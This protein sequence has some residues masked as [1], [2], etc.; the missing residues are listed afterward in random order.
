MTDHIPAS[1]LK[2]ERL[3]FQVS[4]AFVSYQ[5]KKNIM[6]VQLSSLG[7]CYYRVNALPWEGNIANWNT[8][9]LASS[10]FWHG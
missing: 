8:L 7:P 10:G 6:L 2:A 9:V 1:L 5:R 3:M 4:K